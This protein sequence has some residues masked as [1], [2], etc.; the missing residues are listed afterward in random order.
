M[1]ESNQ[2]QVPAAITQL[3]AEIEA[4]PKDSGGKR[5][6]I[7]PELK[8]RVASALAESGMSLPDFSDAV[9]VSPSA[10]FC[11]RKQW[12]KPVKTPSAPRPGKTGGGF[13][14]I[15]VMEEASSGRDGFTIEGPS[16]IRMTGLGAEDVAR[17]WRALC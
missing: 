3:R 13:Q 11:W 10:L 12:T 14:K 1:K 17:L 4:L 7:P 5:K 8:Q 2:R 9:S 16:G 15:T 6:G